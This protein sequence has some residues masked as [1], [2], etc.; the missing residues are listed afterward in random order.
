MVEGDARKSG[1][2]SSPWTLDLTG[3]RRIAMT[4][5]REELALITARTLKHYNERAAEFWDGTRD[6]DVK[7]NVEALLRHI[8]GAPPLRVL[9]FGCGP[10]RDLPHLRALGHE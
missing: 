1:A 7:Q 3:N 4:P 10:W 5:L 8:R 2:R 6:H 9:D